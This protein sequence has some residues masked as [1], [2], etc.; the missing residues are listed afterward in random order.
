MCRYRSQFARLVGA[1][2]IL[3]MCGTSSRGTA[4]SVGSNAK[5]V[6]V[7]PLGR[8]GHATSFDYANLELPIAGVASGNDVVFVGEPLNSAV[9]RCQG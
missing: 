2:L 4:G 6:D 3:L 8:T 7:L 1:S 9:T 5:A